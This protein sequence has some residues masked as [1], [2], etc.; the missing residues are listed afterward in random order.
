MT[1]RTTSQHKDLDAMSHR[2]CSAALSIALIFSSALAFAGAPTDYVKARTAVVSEILGKPDS[3][4]R[5]AELQAALAETVDFRELASRALKGHWEKRTAAEQQEFL[6]LLQRM[7]RA[8]YQNKLQGK[9]LNKDYKLE[10]VDERTR[11]EMALV[12][13]DIILSDGKKPVTY[14]LLQRDQSWIVFDIVVDDIS[15]EE[16]YREDY[17]AIIQ[18][19]GWSSLIQKM[20]DRVAELEAPP[21]KKAAPAKKK[22]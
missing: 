11:R 13:V 6:D 3:K 20:K 12:K 14:K 9:Q 16:T 17:T 1:R 21:K 18:D 4:A 5:A 8:N 19:E 15:L 2:L 22:R 10:Y 7:L